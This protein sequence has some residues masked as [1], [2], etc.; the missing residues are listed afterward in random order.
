MRHL[1]QTIMWVGGYDDWTPAEQREW[2]RDLEELK[3]ECGEK[4]LNDTPTSDEKTVK[5]DTRPCEICPDI[6]KLYQEIINKNIRE[7]TTKIILQSYCCTYLDKPYEVD[8]LPRTH[9]TVVL[10]KL[11]RLIETEIIK[12][13]GYK[14]EWR[15]SFLKRLIFEDER[16]H[17]KDM[18][19]SAT[20]IVNCEK[21][22]N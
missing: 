18:K 17:C 4:Y 1:S 5:M 3:T 12:K 21:V 13:I 15:G 14:T 11:M 19:H 20:N 6:P 8:F 22:S 9:V 2:D 10:K 7:N 16:R